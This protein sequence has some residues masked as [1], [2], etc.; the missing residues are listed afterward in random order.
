MGIKYLKCVIM[1]KCNVIKSV[2]PAKFQKSKKKKFVDSKNYI[3]KISLIIE[4]V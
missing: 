1:Q 2:R 3:V 4:Y